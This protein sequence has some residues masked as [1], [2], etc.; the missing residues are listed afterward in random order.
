M[1]W[2]PK[3]CRAVVALLSVTAMTLLFVM[4]VAWVCT[5]FG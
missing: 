2:M 3:W 5:W 1:T 4:P